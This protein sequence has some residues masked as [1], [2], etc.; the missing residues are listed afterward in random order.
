MTTMHAPRVSTCLPI[1]ESPEPTRMNR[2]RVEAI[3]KSCPPKGRQQPI[4]CRTANR[5]EGQ[6]SLGRTE[7]RPSTGGRDAPLRR[8]PRG[9]AAL[10]PRALSAPRFECSPR[11]RNHSLKSFFTTRLNGRGQTSRPEFRCP[12]PKTSAGE[13]SHPEQAA[14]NHL[15]PTAKNR[16]PPLRTEP[17]RV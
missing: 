14:W 13:V 7:S 1:P 15:D 12:M 2:Q 6:D 16:P 3:R 4:A 9:G 8:L 17:G 5:R 10:H 11:S